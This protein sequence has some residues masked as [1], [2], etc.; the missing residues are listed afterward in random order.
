[1]MYRTSQ[2]QMN[3]V[4]AFGMSLMFMGLM[5]GLVRSLVSTALKPEKQTANLLP[6]TEKTRG[7]QS[8]LPQVLIEGGELIPYQY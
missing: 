8:L 3:D 2:D 1:M 5:L 4:L 6:R 7:D